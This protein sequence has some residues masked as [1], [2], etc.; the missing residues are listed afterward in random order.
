MYDNS[1]KCNKTDGLQNTNLKYLKNYI[2][3]DA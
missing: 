1:S 2:L 3:N